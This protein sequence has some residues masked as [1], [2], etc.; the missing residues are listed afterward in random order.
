MKIPKTRIQNTSNLSSC[1]LIATSLLYNVILHLTPT[2]KEKQTRISENA[3]RS[4]KKIKPNVP[5]IK[6]TCM[7]DAHDKTREKHYCFYQYYNST[8]TDMTS[9][10][11]LHGRGDGRVPKFDKTIDGK[12]N[13]GMVKKKWKVKGN[14]FKYKFCA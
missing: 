14:M 5:K 11:S 6:N 8:I 13:A 4:P 3:K 12:W 7:C 10:R 9:L 2:E 1:H